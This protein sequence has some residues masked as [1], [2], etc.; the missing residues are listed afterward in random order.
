M[1]ENKGFMTGSMWIRSLGEFKKLRVVTFC[2]MMC[3]AAMALNMVASVSLGPYIRIGFSGLPNQVVAYL[4]GPAVGGIFGAALDIIK[5]LIKPEGAFFPGFTVSA[6]VGGIFYGAFLY[7][8]KLSLARVF[9]AQLTVKVFVNLFLNT[10]WL[11]MLY[12]KG[13]MA[14]LPGRVVSNAVML[15]IDTAIMFLML[16][17]VDRTVKKYFDE[18]KE[19]G[20]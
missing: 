11:N 19:R 18:E 14:I 3:A 17:A 12:G 6:A 4:F 2:G 13:F 9:A 5:Y 7:R 1:A 16:Q 20:A 10:L 15:P 8:R